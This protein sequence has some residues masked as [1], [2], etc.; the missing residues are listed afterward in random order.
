[1]PF[2]RKPHLLRKTQAIYALPYRRTFFR[3]TIWYHTVNWTKRPHTTS[4]KTNPVSIQTQPLPG[5]IYPIVKKLAHYRLD[6]LLI[7]GFAQFTVWYRIVTYADGRE[8]NGYFSRIVNNLVFRGEDCI[9]LFRRCRKRKKGR[10]EETKGRKNERK[11]RNEG[12][13]EKSKK[14]PPYYHIRPMDVYHLINH[15]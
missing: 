7:T 15:G 13:M 5:L 4:R 14:H 12:K 11:G 6:F 1:M 9:C 10:N 2:Q 3:I 8:G